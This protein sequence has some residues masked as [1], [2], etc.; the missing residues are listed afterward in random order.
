MIPSI[1]VTGGTG[2][3]GRAF[4]SRMVKEGVPRIIV[5]SRDELKQARMAEAYPEPSPLRFMLGD[6]RDRDRLALAFRGVHTVIHAAALKRVDAVAYDPEEVVKTN[7]L[8]TIN[9]I[10]AAMDAGVACVVVLSSDKSVR[11]A[12]VYG[13]SKFLAEQYAVAS[14]VYAHAAGLRVCATRYGNVLGSRGSVVHTWRRRIAEGLPV[15]VT[16]PQMTRFWMTIGDAVDLVRFA[17]AFTHGG[18]VFIP[19]LRAM[20]IPDLAEALGAH[21]TVIT[22]LRPGGEKLHEELAGPEETARIL[23]AGG[24]YVITPD[25]HPWCET[26]P[27]NTIR[28]PVGTGFSYRSD[29]VERLSVEEMKALLETVGEE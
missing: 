8:G 26:P 27:W 18:E 20:C 2:T 28:R 23:D 6:V 7:V 21:S 12:N 4:V 24:V 17:M 13:A 19:K 10:R 15:T 3:F 9:V 1:C 25:L 16:D 14:N 5:L 29:A 11:A 22:G